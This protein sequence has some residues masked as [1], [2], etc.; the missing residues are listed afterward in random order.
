MAEHLQRVSQLKDNSLFVFGSNR[1]RLAQQQIR[2]LNK[3]QPTAMQATTPTRA[4]LR[5]G[6]IE[7]ES[8]NSG[9]TNQVSGETTSYHTPFRYLQV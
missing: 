1:W 5:V 3:M 4:D 6:T 2:T 8:Q 9:Q 7:R